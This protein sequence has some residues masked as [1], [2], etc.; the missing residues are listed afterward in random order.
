MTAIFYWAED[1]KNY[2]E[3]DYYPENSHVMR[4]FKYLL[5][6]SSYD[7]LDEQFDFIPRNLCCVHKVLDPSTDQ[8]LLTSILISKS[9]GNYT[10]V[11]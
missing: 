9:V 11:G 3:V 10:E 6:L 2:T 1:D 4:V 7:N 8:E 5:R